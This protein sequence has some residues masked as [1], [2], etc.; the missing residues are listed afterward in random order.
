MTSCFDI[1]SFFENI[2][3]FIE[4]KGRPYYSL[5]DF[6]VVVFLSSSSELFVEDEFA[7]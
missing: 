7:V 2:T 4:E 3:G 6:P 5:D 1:A